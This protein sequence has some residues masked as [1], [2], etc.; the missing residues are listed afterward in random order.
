MAS[1]FEAEAR[2]KAKA[3]KRRDA[4]GRFVKGEA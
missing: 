1:A 4:K 2:A 3:M